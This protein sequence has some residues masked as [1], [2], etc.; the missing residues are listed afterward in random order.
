MEESSLR[1]RARIGALKWLG[2]VGLIVFGVLL[3]ITGGSLLTALN[4]PR[5]PQPVSIQQLVDGSIGT[6]QFVSLEGYALYEDGYEEVEDGSV[7][8]TYY[9]MLDEFNGYLVL[10]QASSMS[11][12]DRTSDYIVL[13][14]MT[15][16]TSFDLRDLVRSDAGYYAE[17]GYITT[18]DLYVAEGEK[19]AD[20]A[21]QGFFTVLLAGGFIV[22]I[23]PFFFPTT[24]FMPK[25]ADM[26]AMS[27]PTKKK[28]TDINATGRFL[29]LKKMEPKIEPGKKTRKFVKS[30]AN[31]V[32]FEGEKMMV[33]IHHVVRYNF[34]PISKTHWGVFLAPST[35]SEIQ[36]GVLLGWKDRPAVEFR[37]PLKN[38]KQETL[39]ITF[40]H[41][42]DQADFVKVLRGKGF[43]VGT[44]IGA[45]SI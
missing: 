38:N 43:R 1:F 35:V 3:L 22:S 2:L 31:I 4:N 16:N 30:V 19:P 42:I 28:D 37:F 24:V 9:L 27:V 8:A 5:N 29:Q 20:P 18:P 41:A 44:G 33:Y 7:A 21:V 6:N 12:S 25:P 10:V 15:E 13:T 11:V 34:I 23:V 32:S 17:V 26:S 14:G 40:N 36:Q 45:A 39:L